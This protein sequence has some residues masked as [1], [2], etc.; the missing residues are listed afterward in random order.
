[1]DFY[2]NDPQFIIAMVNDALGNPE[3]SADGRDEFEKW[4]ESETDDV[5]EE[6][7]ICKGSREECNNDGLVCEPVHNCPIDSKCFL[8][9]PAPASTSSTYDYFISSPALQAEQDSC[10]G[11]GQPDCA[12]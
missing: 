9:N 12:Y 6:G 8:K 11:C 2:S 3:K 10:G 4:N 1:M 7:G 5:G